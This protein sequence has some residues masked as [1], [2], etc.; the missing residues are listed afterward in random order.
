MSSVSSSIDWISAFFAG[1][2]ALAALV[3]IYVAQRQ[4]SKSESLSREVAETRADLDKRLHTAAIS[5]QEDQFR[6][7]L[8][9]EWTREIIAWA[10]ECVDCMS[11]AHTLC[12]LDPIRTEEPSFFNRRVALLA[13]ISGL[14]DRGRFFFENDKVG[15]FGAHKEPAYQGYSPEVITRIR[16]VYVLL[17]QV[18]YTRKN[19]NHLMGQSIV[20][21]KRWFVSLIQSEVDPSWFARSESYDRSEDTA[22]D[23]DDLNLK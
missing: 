5:S 17:R 9:S 3:A 11:E 16:S 14:T 15:G 12:E 18:D 8:R 23:P 6:E 20:K 13:R 2:S 10:N 7:T 1:M 21:Q 19:E 4:Y 22:L